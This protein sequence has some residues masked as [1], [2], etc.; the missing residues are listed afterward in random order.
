MYSVFLP[1]LARLGL[2]VNA[3]KKSNECTSLHMCYF[4]ALL[5]HF[6]ALLLTLILN[7]FYS[8]FWFIDIYLKIAMHLSSTWD[9]QQLKTTWFFSYALTALLKQRKNTVC[10][11]FQNP[12]CFL[13][14]Q[15]VRHTPDNI[16]N[17]DEALFIFSA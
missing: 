17:Y 9:Y 4:H 6:V 14:F 10:A 13:L 11:F 16:P 15:V 2:S 7:T 8:F 5:S 1:L 3:W 12:F